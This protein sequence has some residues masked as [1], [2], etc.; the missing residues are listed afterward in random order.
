MSDVLA[1]ARHH[2][3]TGNPG[4]ALAALAKADDTLASSASFWVLRSAARLGQESWDEAADDARRGL[5]LEPESVELLSILSEALK[6]QGDLPAAESAVLAALSLAPD[7]TELLVQYADLVARAGQVEKAEALVER[8]A[9]L[10]PEA[11]A[12]LLARA[13]LAYLK[14]DQAALE[15]HSEA[16]LARDPTGTAGHHMRGVA[17]AASG[18]VHSA[19][20]HYATAAGANPAHH[21]TADLAREARAATHPLLW[22]LWP[23]Q[24]FGPWVVWGVCV[25]SIT[26]L[27]SSGA[28]AVA[29]VA[30]LV[31]IAYVIYTWTVPTLVARHLR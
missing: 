1:L 23:I 20:R 14:G 7:D 2:I 5:E 12:V 28:G 6:Q 15:S 13:E 8:A 26:L 9:A 11:P 27:R 25:G 21:G 16:L 17:M 3:Q 24:R 31:W 22:P 18:R 30:A 10:D 29:A 4:R 19:A